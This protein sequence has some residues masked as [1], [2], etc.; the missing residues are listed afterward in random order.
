ME[1]SKKFIDEEICR[2][3][4]LGKT[5]RLSLKEFNKLTGISKPRIFRFYDSWSDAC[6]ANGI[7]ADVGALHFKK[8]PA[9]SKDACREEIL[10]VANLVSPRPL[11]RKLFAEHSNIST[12]PIKRLWAGSLKKAFQECGVK[13]SE[14]IFEE[15]PFEDLAHEFL[16]VA[17]EVKRV[18]SLV[19]LKR[20]SKH[21]T[22]SFQSKHGGYDSFKVKAISYLLEHEQSR[23][24]ELKV[25]FENELVRLNGNTNRSNLEIRPHEHG[26]MLGFRAFVHVPTYENEIVAIF[27]AIAHEIGFEII[28]NRAEFPDCKANRKIEGSTR[29]RYIECLIEFELRSSDFKAHKHPVNGCDLIVCWEHDWKDCPLEVLELKKTI[30]PLSGWREN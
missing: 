18:P 10:R 13:L 15:T 1:T 12:T 6:K 22:Y 11:T 14:H 24:G 17:A 7:K 5:G 2:A 28:S 20:R 16:L 19:Q 4:S 3:S 26:S 9:I 30:Q 23:I 21:G 25:L 27:G 8:N 29:R